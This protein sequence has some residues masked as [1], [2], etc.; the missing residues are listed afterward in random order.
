[1][2]PRADADA[3]PTPPLPTPTPKAATTTT[4]TTTTTTWFLLDPD[5]W[6]RVRDEFPRSPWGPSGLLRVAGFSAV[7]AAAFGAADALWLTPSAAGAG[8]AAAATTTTASAASASASADPGRAL[9]LAHLAREGALAALLPGAVFLALKPDLD[10]AAASAAAVAASGADS[11]AATATAAADGQQEAPPA[12]RSQRRAPFALSASLSGPHARYWLAQALV[13]AVVAFPLAEPVLSSATA[14]ALDAAQAIAGAAPL[15]SSSSSASF[16]AAVRA[17]AQA[18]DWPSV[19]AHALASGLLAPLWEEVFW[20]GF[21]LASLMRV[22]APTSPRAAVLVSAL[23]F[24]ALHLSP[25]A[26]PSL[27]LLGACCDLLYLRSGGNL[28]APLLFHGL[29][30]AGQVAAV[31]LGVK[32]GFL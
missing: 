19:S 24:S 20:R 22:L 32:D 16:A 30:N 29:W 15:A 6:D 26:A 10:R 17:A 4:T 8:A 25:R 1:V 9:A 12:A 13:T 7:A 31:A 27:A 14:H 11:G 5:L 18:G 3:T 28:A 23:G 21:F 2:P